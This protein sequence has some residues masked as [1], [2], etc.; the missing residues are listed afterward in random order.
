MTRERINNSVKITFAEDTKLLFK[1]KKKK[2]H[3]MTL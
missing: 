1:N 3:N 2:I